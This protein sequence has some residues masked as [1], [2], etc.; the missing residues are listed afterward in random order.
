MVIIMM[1]YNQSEERVDG[2]S[3]ASQEVNLTNEQIEAMI[4][5]N[6]RLRE[7]CRVISEQSEKYVNNWKQQMA[8]H[9]AAWKDSLHHQIV[10]WE[11]CTGEDFYNKYTEEG[12]DLERM[13]CDID[14]DIS[15]YSW[16]DT[17]NASLDVYHESDSAEIKLEKSVDDYEKTDMINRIAK[18]VIEK[19]LSGE[20]YRYSKEEVDNG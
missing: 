18:M 15:D 1:D 6:N 4:I 3:T 20:Y 17:V 5:D 9:T 11:R 2:M 19:F 7:Q 8:K 12:V 10:E 16:E 13:V 14:D